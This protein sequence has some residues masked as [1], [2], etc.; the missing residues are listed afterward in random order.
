MKSY[1]CY[2]AIT[3]GFFD[4]ISPPVQSQM[5]QVDSVASCYALAASKWTAGKFMFTVDEK[6]YS[7]YCGDGSL[8]PKWN[9]K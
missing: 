3:R 1:I 5:Y 7:Y 6:E 2:L 4:F 8:C 9:M